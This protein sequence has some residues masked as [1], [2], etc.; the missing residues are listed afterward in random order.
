MSAVQGDPVESVNATE[1]EPSLT[2]NDVAVGGQ[3]ELPHVTIS[4]LP[5]PG[6]YAAGAPLS[7][8]STSG[9]GPARRESA[10][11]AEEQEANVM[12]TIMVITTT[13]ILAMTA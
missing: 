9:G 8:T 13:L 7:V 10:T 4:M 6:A 3:L 11:P 1:A 5:S 2:V 12:T